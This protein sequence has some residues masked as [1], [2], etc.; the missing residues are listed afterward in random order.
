VP[1]AE[2]Y[3]AAAQQFN[4]LAELDEEEEQVKDEAQRTLGVELDDSKN[5]SLD[6]G[7]VMSEQEEIMVISKSNGVNLTDARKQLAHFPQE[8]IVQEQTIPDLI[9]KLRDARRGLKGSDRDKMSKAIDTLI[10][11]YS[12]HLNK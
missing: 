11:A 1:S 3:R 8:Y 12:D 6:L 7:Y 9:H 5:A 4:R 2:E 10:D